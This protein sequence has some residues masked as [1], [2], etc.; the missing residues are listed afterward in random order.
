M[1][2]IS[3]NYSW[4]S[5]L[6]TVVNCCCKSSYTAIVEFK[7]LKRTQQLRPVGWVHAFGWGDPSS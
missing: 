4:M 7:V 1:A 5:Q 3:N 2:F 6:Q